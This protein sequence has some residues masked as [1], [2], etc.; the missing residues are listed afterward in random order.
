MPAAGS[1]SRLCVC[2]VSLSVKRI[3]EENIKR[4]LKIWYLTTNSEWNVIKEKK[5]KKRKNMKNK[6][7]AME[8]ENNYT[9][10]ARWWKKEFLRPLMFKMKLE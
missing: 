5:K 8:K 2:A 9:E 1:K 4:I 7:V 3:Q 6:R 10:M